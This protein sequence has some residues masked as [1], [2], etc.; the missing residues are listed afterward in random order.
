MAG[1]PT[2]RSH[3]PGLPVVAA[4]VCAAV[5][6]VHRLPALPSPAGLVP[7]AILCLLALG[8]PC[9][10]WW[11]V[12]VAAVIWTVWSAERRLDGRLPDALTGRDFE[13]VGWVDGFPAGSPARRTFSFVVERADDPAV[14]RRLRLGWYDAPDSLAAGEAFALTVRL[15]APRGQMNPG[16][17]D[18]ERWL[19]V[20]GYGATGYVRSGERLEHGPPSVARW[21]L[22]MRGAAAERLAAAAPSPD[23]AALL[24]ALSIG[25]RFG[26][27]DAHWE[28]L[29]RTG[30]SHL[31][32]ISGLHVG[33]VATLAFAA[34]RRLWVRLPAAVACRDLEAA[35]AAAALAGVG[36]AALAGFGVPTQRAAVMILVALGVAVGRR[37]VGW[38]NGL[39][40]ALLAVIAADPFAVLA[41]SFWLSFGAVALL[42]A[43]ASRRDVSLGPTS[44]LARSR[45]TALALAALQLTMSFGLV[46]VAAAYFGEISLIS[47]IA[48]VV[49]IPCFSLVLVPLALAALAAVSCGL[50][51]AEALAAFA[52]HLADLAWA[53]IAAAARMPA[54]AWPLAEAPLAASALAAVGVVLGIDRKSVV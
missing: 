38:G 29:R 7:A 17:F 40:A 41:A 4:A 52:G 12:V 24:I 18:Y 53:G 23:A 46:P 21:W 50:P 13:V 6:A 42:V 22:G 30:T 15:R 27:D 10:R 43:L 49:A 19:L 26:F 45:R 32:A 1:N 34:V 28:D 47:P 35:A 48:N 20:E 14:P 3:G 25:E 36:Y 8:R 51:G 16:G 9:T 37:A 31:V 39:A 5:V 54:A 11:I 44:V 33:L 2:A